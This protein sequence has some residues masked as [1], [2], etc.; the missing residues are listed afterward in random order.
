MWLHLIARGACCVSAMTGE[1][2]VCGDSATV[3]WHLSAPHSLSSLLP[4]SPP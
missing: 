1:N 3:T 2:T 4:F